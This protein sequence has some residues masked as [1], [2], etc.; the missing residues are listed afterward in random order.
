MILPSVDDE[1]PTGLELIG[2]ALEQKKEGDKV[3]PRR[4]VFFSSI[5]RISIGAM[6]LTCLFFVVVQEDNVI[7][8][9]FDILA[10]EFVESIDD[11]IYGLCRRGFFSRRLKVAANQ[12]NV[13]QCSSS[14]SARRIRRWSQRFIRAFYFSCAIAMLVGLSIVTYQQTQGTY[15]CRSLIMKFD[16]PTSIAIAHEK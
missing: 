3:F 14:H 8:I 11:V 2:K 5:L 1:I 9:F 4:K 10:L 12:E 6:F 7:D 15:G 16:K 13:L